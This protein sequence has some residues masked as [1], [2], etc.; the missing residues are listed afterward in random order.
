MVEGGA[1]MLSEDVMLDALYTA[2]DAL[3]PLIKMQEELRAKL[4]KPKREVVVAEIDKDIQKAVEAL[5]LPR[6]EKAMTFV[7][8]HGAPRRDLGGAQGNAGRGLEQFPDQE[9]VI[10][11]VIDESKA[12]P[13]GR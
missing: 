12:T 9:A 4:G 6:I 3:Q 7:A 2:L 1:K 5:A 10:R 8:K 13:C 11:E